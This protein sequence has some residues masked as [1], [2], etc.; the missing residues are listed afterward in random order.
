[1]QSP[2]TQMSGISLVVETIANTLQEIANNPNEDPSQWLHR[3]F[4]ATKVN[5]DV[6]YTLKSAIENL[7]NTYLIT[8]PRS[9]SPINVQKLKRLLLE[10]LFVLNKCKHKK[11]LK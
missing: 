10:V 8:T 1:M 3:I 5:D 2:Q 7:K 4:I 9:N 11:K 6:Q